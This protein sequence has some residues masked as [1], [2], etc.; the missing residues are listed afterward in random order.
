LGASE[1]GLR[2]RRKANRPSEW[3]TNSDPT[4]PDTNT[5][6]FFIVTLGSI[7]RGNDGDLTYSNE[8]FT[9][10]L[11]EFLHRAETYLPKNFMPFL[12]TPTSPP[13]SFKL[14]PYMDKQAWRG[15][16]GS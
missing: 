7:V 8:S 4:N 2:P 14:L 5:F 1:T 15:G 11:V 16:D 9:G 3:S 10:T 13:K 6:N 12:I